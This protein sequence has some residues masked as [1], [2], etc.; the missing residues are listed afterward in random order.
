MLSVF[1][2]RIDAPIIV[3]HELRILSIVAAGRIDS[4]HPAL[5]LHELRLCMVVAHELIRGDWYPLF[6]EGALQ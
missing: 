6:A 3:H 1:L 2:D 5:R 4:N